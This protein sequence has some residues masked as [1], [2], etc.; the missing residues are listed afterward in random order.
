[1]KEKLSVL[2][3]NV[4]GYEEQAE[5]LR[6]IADEL[7]GGVCGGEGQGYSYRLYN[8]DYGDVVEEELVS[9]RV[10]KYRNLNKA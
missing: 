4:T 6:K 9:T 2:F 3:D 7:E 5:V 8:P 1:M 10:E